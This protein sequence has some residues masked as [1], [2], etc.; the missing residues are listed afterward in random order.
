MYDVVIIGAGPGGLFAAYELKEKNKD[1]P[2][3]PETKVK[4]Q[5]GRSKSPK[6]QID[7]NK[8]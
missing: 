7:I 8:L 5:A 2:N 3:V 4:V 1:K 6:K